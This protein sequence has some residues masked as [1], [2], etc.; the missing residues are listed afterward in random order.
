MTTATLCHERQRHSARGRALAARSR[1]H[2]ADAWADL[3]PDSM[4]I[5]QISTSYPTDGADPTAPFIRSIARALVA[6]GHEV[7]I[8]VPSRAGMPATST[9]PGIRVDWVR[10]APLQRLNVIGHG[11]SL[12]NDALLRSSVYAALPLF[13]VAA[14]ARALAI[15]REWKPAVVQSHWALPG[16]L[17]GALAAKSSGLPHVV[18]LHGS[19]VYV[20]SSKA[21]FRAVARW[22]FRNSRA[23]TACSP[24]LAEQAVQLGARR[25]SAHF[26]PYGV[27]PVQFR[28]RDG[29]VPM[30]S[31]RVV[32]AVG[33]LVEKKGF[34]VLIEHAGVFLGTNPDIQLWIAGEG[35][36]RVTLE[37]KIAA[38]PDEQSR[39]VKL[40][41]RVEWQ[42]MPD[43]LRRAAVFVM[44]SVHDSHG[45]QDG[46]PNVILEAMSCGAAV[47]A[48]EIGGASDVIENGRTGMIVSSSDGPGLGRTI[49]ELLS[50]PDR[51][52]SIGAAASDLIRS[53]YTWQAM[54]SRLEMIFDA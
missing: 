54:A 50:D 15:I 19:D 10:Y 35:D 33:R 14:Y 45:N 29:R 53:R 9:E 38:L 25:G 52:D 16:G 18:S 13:L 41:G 34:R 28:A 48:T 7:R 49:A 51:R 44:P 12:Q 27:D 21:A 26:L 1:N 30:E 46:L 43:L 5:L 23:V 3:E 11:R 17:V 22:V 39:R 20:A 2:P 40:L 47:V 4:R 6:E 36:D 24:Y 31:P 32:L 8:I 37:R 42:R